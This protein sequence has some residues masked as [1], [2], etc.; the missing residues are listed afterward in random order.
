MGQI[1]RVRVMVLNATS[2]NSA[3]ISWWYNL[4]VEETEI[5]KK[6]IDLSECCIEYTSPWTGFE[7]RT[8]VV[9]G[10]YCIGSYKS[11]HHTITTTTAP[12]I[13]YLVGMTTYWVRDIEL[14][15]KPQT[16][17]CLATIKQNHLAIFTRPLWKKNF[18]YLH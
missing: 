3:V 13:E 1:Y 17:V 4:L 14:H 9:I 5:P 7:L 18:T 12:L 8:S 16:F 2:N 10:T 15:V 11:N 6:I